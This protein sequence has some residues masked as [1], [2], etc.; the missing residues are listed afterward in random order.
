MPRKHKRPGVKASLV[1]QPLV[2]LYKATRIREIN[3]T[4]ATSLTEFSFSL[5]AVTDQIHQ[6]SQ[7]A[8]EHTQTLTQN[9]YQFRTISPKN[10]K[11]T[12]EFYTQNQNGSEF[13]RIS[14]KFSE[15]HENLHH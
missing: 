4:E 14:S 8:Q 15:I 10:V 9:R 2:S 11:F 13:T 12:S 5:L 3:I 6:S 1:Q 7:E